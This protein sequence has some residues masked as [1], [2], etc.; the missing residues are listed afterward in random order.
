MD[1]VVLTESSGRQGCVLGSVTFCIAHEEGLGDLREAGRKAD[2]WPC[3]DQPSSH[4]PV[5]TLR[6]NS[7]MTQQALLK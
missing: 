5:G 3:M 6:K 1:Q 2:L 4:A 7:H